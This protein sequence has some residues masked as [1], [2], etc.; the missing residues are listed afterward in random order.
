MVVVYHVSLEGTLLTDGGGGGGKKKASG[1][2]STCTMEFTPKST[3]D[4]RGFEI[5]RDIG[6]VLGG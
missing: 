6:D 5:H 1:G 3:Y 2:A 4:A